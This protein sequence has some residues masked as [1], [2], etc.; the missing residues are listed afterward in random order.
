MTS[1]AESS[2][3]EKRPET[4]R[5]TDNIKLKHDD[6][7]LNIAITF[8]FELLILEPFSHLDSLWSILRVQ[9]VNFLS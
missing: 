5:R 8:D 1:V 2:W 7:Q 9:I 6:K 3:T 4:E